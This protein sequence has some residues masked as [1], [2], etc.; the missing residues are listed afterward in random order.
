MKEKLEK[1]FK[2]FDDKAKKYGLKDKCKT[3]EKAL[4]STDDKHVAY[5]GYIHP[6]NNDSSV[7]SDLSFVGFPN[8]TGDKYL[9][10]IGVGTN[11]FAEDY[12]I[13]TT[14]QWRRA[15]LK[16]MPKDKK[17]YA[18]CKT[19]FA[20]IEN[21]S[22]TLK[23]G[24]DNNDFNSK[25]YTTYGKLLPASIIVDINEDDDKKIA[26]AWLAQYAK[27]RDGNKTYTEPDIKSGHKICS[28]ETDQEAN[29]RQL[30]ETRRFVIL[31]G[32]PG[33]GKT[34]MAN[35]IAGEEG[36]YKE[37]FFTQFHAE[38]SYTDFIYGILPD[39]AN[40]DSLSYR[41]H[42]GVLLRAI[43]EASKPE[44]KTNKYLLVI[45]EINRANLS[46]VLG[47]V[48]Y[49]FEPSRKDGKFTIN[50]G[51]E[52]YSEIPENLYVLGTMNTADRSIAVVDYAL[53][54]R[55][56][57]YNIEP[58]PFKKEKGKKFHEDIFNAFAEIF[59]NYA[60]DD[61]LNL[62]PGPSYFQTEGVNEETHKTLMSD[63]L[64]YELMPLIKEYLNEGLLSKA[65][66]DFTELFYKETGKLLFK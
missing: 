13:A 38:T 9:I 53:R 1:T 29:I 58:K 63:R 34:Y 17:Y 24:L 5:F 60:T 22:K 32:A 3:R 26:F 20:D 2:L 31:Q 35:K 8:D 23:E 56:A 65:K 37:V 62:Q 59:E 39:T 4:Y 28:V 30:L 36:A 15:F 42:K 44:N 41:E 55:F 33:V 54:R 18:Q 16:L 49:L 57:W 64:E 45:D 14:P 6:N 50:I 7:Y 61:E 27:L 48:F 12:E 11:G 19:S 43:E 10:A 25:I 21:G 52:N 40:K 47:P 46:S 51:G 66:N